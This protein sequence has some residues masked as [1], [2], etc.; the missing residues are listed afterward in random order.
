MT[1]RNLPRMFRLRL[2]ILSAAAFCILFFN[3]AGL[4][5][6]SESTR[7][8]NIPAGEAE[9]TFRQFSEQAGVQFIYSADKIRNVRTNPVTGDLTPRQAIERL[10]AGTPLVAV[11]DNKTG[12]LTVDRQPAENSANP[13]PQPTCGSPKKKRE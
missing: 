5:A 10:I 7:S 3:A 2:R 13:A 6:Q 12:A 9:G 4:F 8:F 11:Y 1:V